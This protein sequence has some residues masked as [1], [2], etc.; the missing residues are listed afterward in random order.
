VFE[1]AVT[2]SG[3]A[4]GLFNN[5]GVMDRWDPFGEV[6]RALGGK[7]LAINLTGAMVSSQ[8]ALQHFM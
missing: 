5:A 8:I 3:H 2:K 4:D 7:I 1:A 6:L